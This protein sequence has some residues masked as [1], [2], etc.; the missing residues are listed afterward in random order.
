MDL[1]LDIA[2]KFPYFKEHNDH[3][4]LT[5]GTYVEKLLELKLRDPQ[6]IFEYDIHVARQI[7]EI[8]QQYKRKKNYILFQSMTVREHIPKDFYESDEN[9]LRYIKSISHYST[10]REYGMFKLFLTE[11]EESY[12]TVSLGA[13]QILS[14]EISL[15]YYFIRSSFTTSIINRLSETLPNLIIKISEGQLYLPTPQRFPFLFDPTTPKIIGDVPKILASLSQNSWEQYIDILYVF[16]RF[17]NFH[18]SNDNA[19]LI[20][21]VLS[22][23]YNLDKQ[24]L[25]RE[26]ISNQK[27]KP[28]KSCVRVDLKYWSCKTAVD[29]FYHI[30][31]KVFDYCNSLRD[32][33]INRQI[34]MSK[35][36][37]GIA[38]KLFAC[39]P[40]W[41]YYLP[42][43]FPRKKLI[44]PK[45]HW[46][47]ELI[48]CGLAKTDQPDV[49]DTRSTS[50]WAKFL[51]FGLYDP[52]LFLHIFAFF[53]DQTQLLTPQI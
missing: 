28:C 11:N 45:Y 20:L 39:F 19:L 31:E 26:R 51:R 33:I 21:M 46:L 41:D 44:Y 9:L 3:E 6:I 29:N 5:Y 40:S 36:S 17:K 8:I 4:P 16:D 15:V 2:K 14:E 34:E 7:S 18:I 38:L 25:F 10:M 22:N 47:A 32:K 24:F 37:R 1:T 49:W 13:L 27:G 23:I 50:S 43:E 35:E 42:S 52:R 53:W 48:A 12:V 30:D